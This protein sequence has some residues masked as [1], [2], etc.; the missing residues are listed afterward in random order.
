MSASKEHRGLLGEERPREQLEAA[1]YSLQKHMA[2]LGMYKQALPDPLRSP[3][4]VL[5]QVK[6]AS[7]SRGL[8]G[9]AVSGGKSLKKE[10]ANHCLG[11]KVL[12][13]SALLFFLDRL[14]FSLFDLPWEKGHFFGSLKIL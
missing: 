9:G 10:A 5:L 13:E 4:I 6:G 2:P 1:S 3:V 14:P 11:L 7:F 12:G 8:R